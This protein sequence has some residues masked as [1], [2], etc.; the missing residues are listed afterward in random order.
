ME[1]YIPLVAPSMI[2]LN[3][4]MGVR[5]TSGVEF[6]LK[7]DPNRNI[8]FTIIVKVAE[9]LIKHVPLAHCRLTGSVYRHRKEEEET[10]ALNRDNEKVKINNVKTYCMH[11]RINLVQKN[12]FNV[13]YY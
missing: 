7:C 13:I 9:H 10:P 5:E 6:P 1:P 3:H 12:L 8:A 4:C 11:K 2:G